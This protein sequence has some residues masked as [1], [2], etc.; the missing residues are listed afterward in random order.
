MRENKIFRL[1][2]ESTFLHIDPTIEKIDCSDPADHFFPSITALKAGLT[3]NG[4]KCLIK[5][6]PINC[7]NIKTGGTFD[8]IVHK[9]GLREYCNARL[10]MDYATI[11]V[12]DKG[13]FYLKRYDLS[14]EKIDEEFVE[15]IRI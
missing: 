3:I 10:L 4:L 5:I 14:L 8:D 7:N 2:G 15:S 12:N 6:D 9:M 11:Y 1:L 13:E